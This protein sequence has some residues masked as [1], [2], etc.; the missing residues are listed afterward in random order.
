MH[1][2][3]AR[4]ATADI[5][6]I[7]ALAGAAGRAETAKHSTIHAIGTVA[8]TATGTAGC[9][10]TTGSATIARKRAVY[11]SGPKRTI[12][13]M[14][15]T[16]SAGMR[17]YPIWDRPRH[18]KASVA[19]SFS[20][21]HLLRTIRGGRLHFAD[22]FVAV[23][24]PI[25]CLPPWAPSEL[26]SIAHCCVCYF[27]CVCYLFTCVLYGLLPSTFFLNRVIVFV[28]CMLSLLYFMS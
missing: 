10:M 16:Y 24:V 1:T 4:H 18:P 11:A 26:S 19:R 3:G 22:R 17:V 14:I 9:A 5:I 27:C 13:M 8:P 12:G 20:S 7:P 21:A 2:A 25:L 23:P 6:R 15:D 28:C